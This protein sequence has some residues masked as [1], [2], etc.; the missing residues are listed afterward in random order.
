M[1]TLITPLPM[2]APPA[3]PQAAGLVAR[4]GASGWEWLEEAGRARARREL[5]ALAASYDTTQPELAK[6]LR[7]ACGQVL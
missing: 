5:S 7:A 2:N 4:M 6:E 3:G 1:N